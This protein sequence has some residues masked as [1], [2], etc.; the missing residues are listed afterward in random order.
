MEPRGLV[1][2]ALFTAAALIAACIVS[3]LLSVRRIQ[4]RH[5]T[6]WEE[7]GQPYGPFGISGAKYSRWLHNRGYLK[8]EDL[9]LIRACRFQRIGPYMATVLGLIAIIASISW[10]A[11]R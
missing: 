10:R 11:S 5:R 6:V 4:L 9:G 1:L 7:L 8:T 3:A 2:T